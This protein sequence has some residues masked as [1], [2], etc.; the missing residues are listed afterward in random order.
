MKQVLALLTAMLLLAGVALAGEIDGDMAEG[1][2]S[3]AEAGDFA[4]S[5][6]D[7]GYDGTWV[8]IP[9]LGMELCLP[10]GWTQEERPDALYFARKDDGAADMMICLGAGDVAD[11]EAWAEAKRGGESPCALTQVGFYPGAVREDAEGRLFVY[12]LTDGGREVVFRFTRTDEEA[13][14]QEFALTIAGTLYE[15]LFPE[16]FSTDDAADDAA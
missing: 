12:V 8:Q 15:D 9:A 6:D 7:E 16:D 3:G 1:F 10:E 4:F 2:D 5:F 11:P 14:T 13:L